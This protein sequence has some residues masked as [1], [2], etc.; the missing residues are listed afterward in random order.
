VL[1]KLNADLNAVLAEAPIRERFEQIGVLPV[2]GTLAAS[3]AYVHAEIKK[4]G[5]V[6]RKIGLR[7]D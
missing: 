7:I 1:T 2:G 4:W 5:D 6:V 3:E